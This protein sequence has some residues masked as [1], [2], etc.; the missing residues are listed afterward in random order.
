M[1]RDGTNLFNGQPEPIAGPAGILPNCNSSRSEITERPAMFVAFSRWRTAES[2]RLGNEAR[3]LP[4]KGRAAQ[5]VE[6][7]QSGTVGNCGKNRCG[8]RR[9]LRQTL[10]HAEIKRLCCSLGSYLFE[11][12]IPSLFDYIRMNIDHMAALVSTR[13]M[14]P[15]N[16]GPLRS[17]HSDIFRSTLGT[18]QLWA[19]PNGSG[20]AEPLVRRISHGT[21][22]GAPW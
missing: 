21:S 12:A 19:P 22:S 13:R 6:P 18:D 9:R 7:R 20:Q 2:Q 16:P 8:P 1:A 15:R 11:R 17:G 10:I 4:S 14:P 5:T 3:S